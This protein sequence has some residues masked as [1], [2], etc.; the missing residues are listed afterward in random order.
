VVLELIELK[1]LGAV[2]CLLT[3]TDPMIMLKHT[4]PERYTKLEALL[5]NK[6]DPNEVYPG[7]SSK[8]KRRMD[9]AQAL[10]G[11]VSVVPP[12]RLMALL[13]QGRLCESALY[14]LQETKALRQFGSLAMLSLKWQQHQGLLPPGMSIDLF[15]GKT[16]MKDLDEERFPT[17]LSHLLK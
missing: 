14:R 2:T 10:V 5:S 16:M 6:F 13:G 9:I 3:Q 7:G 8:E 12:S 17:Q 4:Q 1:E 15:R 11:E